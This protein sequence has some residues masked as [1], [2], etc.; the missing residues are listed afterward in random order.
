M[1]GEK[2]RISTPTRLKFEWLDKNYSSF[3]YHHEVIVGLQK[4]FGGNQ[5][6]LSE[7]V[8]KYLGI[9]KVRKTKVEDSG[10][11][12]VMQECY[13]CHSEEF[14]VSHHYSYFPEKLVTLCVSCHIKIHQIMN[15]QHDTMRSINEKAKIL[16]HDVEQLDKISKCANRVPENV[17]NGGKQ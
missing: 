15:E 12:K 5:K 8:R 1:I 7:V 4:E 10:K 3:T 13:F 16:L 11:T 9:S 2:K 6:R 14:L 17:Q